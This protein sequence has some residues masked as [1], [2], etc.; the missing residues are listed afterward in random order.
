MV[1]S[2][3]KRKILNSPGIHTKLYGRMFVEKRM[4]QVYHNQ[5]WVSLSINLQKGSFKLRVAIRRA[6]K[7]ISRDPA[8][9]SV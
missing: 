1:C 7:S 4:Q 2:K 9:A 6:F 5:K 3:F 8:G